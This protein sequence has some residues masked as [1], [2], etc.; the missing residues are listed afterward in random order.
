MC[1][2]STAGNITGPKLKFQAVSRLI[3]HILANSRAFRF[4]PEASS[5]V[6][7]REDVDGYEIRFAR[8]VRYSS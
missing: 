5:S 6:V 4:N 2:H 8:P 1:A 7:R 3:P